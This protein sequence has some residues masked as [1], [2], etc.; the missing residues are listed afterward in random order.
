MIA[1]A[2]SKTEK[3]FWGKYLGLPVTGYSLALFTLALAKT[4]INRTTEN[5]CY[6]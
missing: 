6:R 2:M 5:E 1:E 4:V 3:N